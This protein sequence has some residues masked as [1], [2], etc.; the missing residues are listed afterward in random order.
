MH[1]PKGGGDRPSC[2]NLV[3]SSTTRRVPIR[4]V[5]LRGAGDRHRTVLLRQ[6]DRDSFRAAAEMVD[7]GA[8]PLRSRSTCFRAAR[9]PRS[10]SRTAPC[11]GSPS[12]MAARRLC[13][14]QRRGLRGDRRAARGGRVSARRGPRC[15]GRR[16][17]DPAPA[18]RWRG[19]RQPAL[20]DRFRRL[21]RRAAFR[22]RRSPRGSG[23]T[24]SGT[25]DELVPSSWHSCPAAKARERSPRR[26]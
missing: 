15:R 1:E 23:F 13:M 12:R 3:R 16:R 18:G 14:G 2:W 11:H 10:R 25:I 21:R 8:V 26:H 20:K 9:P 4:A 24:F 19:A 17:S 7:A 5:L 22:W 6:H